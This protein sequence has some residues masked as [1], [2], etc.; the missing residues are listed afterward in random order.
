MFFFLGLLNIIILCLLGEEH[1]DGNLTQKLIY[2]EGKDISPNWIMCL[3][4][5]R[6][7]SK[8]GGILVTIHSDVISTLTKATKRRKGSFGLAV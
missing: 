8:E 7:L 4:R 6:S 5:D 2:A 3:S 1:Y